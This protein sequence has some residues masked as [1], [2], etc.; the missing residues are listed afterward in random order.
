MRSV[1]VLLEYA[2][3][4]VPGTHSLSVLRLI[5]SSSNVHVV[6]GSSVVEVVQYAVIILGGHR[7]SVDHARRYF[8]G[9]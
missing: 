9:S 5:R 1:E 8:L 2:V 3:N 4:L 6:K 7:E